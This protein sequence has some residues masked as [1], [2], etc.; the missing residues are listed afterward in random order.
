MN[1]VQISRLTTAVTSEAGKIPNNGVEDFYCV[2]VFYDVTLF[3]KRFIGLPVAQRGLISPLWLAYPF[4]C[5]GFR[6]LK[7]LSLSRCDRILLL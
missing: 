5:V 7:N 3:S 4:P 1:I 6:V 2:S